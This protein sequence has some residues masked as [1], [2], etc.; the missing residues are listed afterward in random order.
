MPPYVW[1]LV[2]GLLLPHPSKAAHAPPNPV[3]ILL[4]RVYVCTMCFPVNL[5]APEDRVSNKPPV[6]CPKVLPCQDLCVL[7]DSVMDQQALGWPDVPWVYNVLRWSTE[8]PIGKAVP[9]DFQDGLGCGW[10]PPVDS[11]KRSTVQKTDESPGC[12]SLQAEQG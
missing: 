12:L 9:G 1:V 4:G 3:P 7:H 2:K 8:G 11:H 6:S 5:K 10:V